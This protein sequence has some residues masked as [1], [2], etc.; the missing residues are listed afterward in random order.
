MRN[1]G[2]AGGGGYVSAMNRRGE[3]VG[4]YYTTP[5][6][7]GSRHPFRWSPARG[8]RD[9]GTLGGPSGDPGGINARGIV[10]GSSST[11]GGNVHATVWL[12]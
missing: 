7:Q 6:G 10:A 5:D 3:A 8:R 11:T 12:P 2:P 4:I 1:I 9:L